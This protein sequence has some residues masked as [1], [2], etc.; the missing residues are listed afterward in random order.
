CIF[1]GSLTIRWRLASGVDGGRL[2]P[3][4]T[5]AAQEQ[6]SE[7]CPRAAE[8]LSPDVDYRPVLRVWHCT[9]QNFMHK[10]RNIAFSQNQEAKQVSDRVP[11]GPLKVSVRNPA[12]AAFE[13]KQEGRDG[14]GNGRARR[15]QDSVRS[16]LATP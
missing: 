7:L 10:R 9:P 16:N 8:S 4:Y 15:P 5:S 14:V 1:T 12:C 2:L 6:R 13:M 3:L 11:L